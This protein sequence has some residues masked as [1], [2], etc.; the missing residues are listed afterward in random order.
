MGTRNKYPGI[1]EYAVNL[2]QV[3]SW[4]LI[5][6]PGFRRADREDV[7]QDLA[8]CLLMRLPK[9]DAAVA[10]RNTFISRIVNRR[11]ASIIAASKAGKRDW[12][13]RAFSLDS[14][15]PD[16]ERPTQWRERVSEEEYLLSVGLADRS[17]EDHREMVMD[18]ERTLERL[19]E[20][21]RD[22]CERLKTQTVS[23]ISSEL[24]MPRSTIYEAIRKVR[25]IFDEAGLKNY[26]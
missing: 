14:N 1:E 3:K 19:P 17:P 23:D 15:D 11:V 9:Y 16:C 4:Q 18:V 5:N 26:L 6:Q 25:E 12:R 8:L 24:G 10:K 13:M 7:E 21:F 2:I 20:N 22:L